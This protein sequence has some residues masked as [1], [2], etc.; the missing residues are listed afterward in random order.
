MG[1][2]EVS[3]SG[4]PMMRAMVLEFP[5][6]PTSAFLDRQYM[7]GGA[8]WW[9]RSS[10]TMAGSLTTSRGEVDAPRDERHRGGAGWVRECHDFSGL[11]L[12]VRPGSVVAMGAR[13]DRADYD[14][15]DGVT[16]RAFELVEAVDVSVL[17][18]DSTE[19]PIP[20]SW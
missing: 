8:C 5:D 19:R 16:L 3:R 4:V 7:L 2:V 12:L 13:D 20:R 10:Q 15:A 14:F 1:G 11:P 18:P 17:V 9:R 6:D